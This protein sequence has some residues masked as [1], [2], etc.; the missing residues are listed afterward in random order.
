MTSRRRPTGIRPTLN[1]R[2]SLAAVRPAVG[3]RTV[4]TDG[5][6]TATTPAVRR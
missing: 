6:R 2:L 4:M 1:D 3:T 5:P